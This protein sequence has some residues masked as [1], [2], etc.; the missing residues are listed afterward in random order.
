VT[1]DDV[2]ASSVEPCSTPPSGDRRASGRCAEH[3][4]AEAL[5]SYGTTSPT[6]ALA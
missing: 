2:L 3:D 6:C 4:L 5:D 1:Q